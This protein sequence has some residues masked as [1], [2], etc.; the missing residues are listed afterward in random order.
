MAILRAPAWDDA[1]GSEL[2]RLFQLYFPARVLALTAGEGIIISAS[3][4]LATLIQFGP[5]SYLVLTNENG[6]AKILSVTVA[7]LLSSYYFDLYAPQELISH[8]DT[9]V[10]VLTVLG[11]MASLLG[12]VGYVAPHFMFG[13]HVFLLGLIISTS[14]L[15]LW[16]HLYSWLLKR[17]F[18][19][20]RVYLLGSGEPARHLLEVM[21]TRSDLGI[22][23]VGW[24]DGN[25]SLARESFAQGLIAVRERRS[26]DRVIVA[27]TDRRG[28]IPIRELLDLRLSGVKVED[29]TA[30]LEQLSGKIEIDGLYPSWFIFSEGF[31]VNR[32]FLFFRRMISIAVSLACLLVCLPLIP[33][34][35]LAIRISSPGPVFYRQARV[36]LNGVIFDCYKFRT[37][38]PNAEA[39]T[40]P[41]WAGDDDPRVS[42]IGL[43]LRKTRLDEIPQ[44]WNV[45]RGDMV[46]VGPRPERPEFIEWLSREIS[47]Y[48]LRHVVPPGITGWAQVCYKYG[49]SIADAKEK[50]KYDLFYIKNLSFGF[51]LLILLQTIKVVLLGL[52]AK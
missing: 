45:L 28:T 43:I 47:Y 11:L 2:V 20:E 17:P 35:I 10:R 18:L 36:G 44:L 4:L 16:R 38:V 29:A 32:T 6:L 26:V 31:R 42:G 5:H 50:L 48:Q 40:G 52:G 25:E 22:E 24:A 19:R 39:D 41:T 30:L 12:I 13:K 9:Y 37:M 27:V 33:L 14:A 49:N 8:A 51:D 21:R 7:V 34:I 15:V 3:F 1:E 23:L 46:F